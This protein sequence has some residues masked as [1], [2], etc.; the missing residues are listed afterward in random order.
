MDEPVCRRDPNR[1]PHVGGV[2]F[3]AEF[4]P[5][6]DPARFLRVAIELSFG[7]IYVS[8]GRYLSSAGHRFKATNELSDAL[9]RQ[10]C[11]EEYVRLDATRGF[12]VQ[13]SRYAKFH[14]LVTYGHETQHMI[15]GETI[16][17]DLDGTGLVELTRDSVNPEQN[18]NYDFRWD[19]PGRRFR[20]TET[21]L[22]GLQFIGELNF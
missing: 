10:L 22:F 5:Y 17:V 9:G 4:L 16:G 12:R 1:P 18:P 19:Q 13:A 15:T 8:E 6:V 3:G 20:M 11:S 2:H 14:I 21:T 7:A